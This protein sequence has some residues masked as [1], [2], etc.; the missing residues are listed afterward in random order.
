M[1][2]FS[3]LESLFQ[4]LIILFSTICLTNNKWNPF[5]RFETLQKCCLIS[6]LLSFRTNSNPFCIY[7]LFI[8]TSS[9]ANNYLNDIWM[10]EY[11]VFQKPFSVFSQLVIC[12]F[13]TICFQYI[14]MHQY[15]R[16]HL[17]FFF[18]FPNKFSIYVSIW[19]LI[20]DSEIRLF[21]E[22]KWMQMNRI[23]G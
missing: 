9:N 1:L 3:V 8:T 6:I 2:S 18:R 23:E 22:I 21:Q 5:Y 13:V 14:H 4:T 10:N 17:I 11:I 20:M 19:M 7:M 12:I 15:Y 16:F